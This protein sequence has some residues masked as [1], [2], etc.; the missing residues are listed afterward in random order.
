MFAGNDALAGVPEDLDVFT[1]LGPDHYLSG[2]TL[3]AIFRHTE[4]QL[5][6]M[7]VVCSSDLP[8]AAGIRVGAQF[9]RL[10]D[11]LDAIYVDAGNAIGSGTEACADIQHL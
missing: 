1:D 3:P 8:G 9:D 7:A 11:G 5:V 6:P 10:L 2:E 4:E